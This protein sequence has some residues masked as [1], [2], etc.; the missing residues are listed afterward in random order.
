MPTSLAIFLIVFMIAA[1][2]ALH[3]M[4]HV[5]DTDFGILGGLVAMAVIYCIGLTMDRCGL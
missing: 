1:A 5:I 3:L 2:Y 4:A